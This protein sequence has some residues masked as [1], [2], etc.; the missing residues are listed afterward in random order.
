VK[1]DK[2][3][4]LSSSKGYQLVVTIDIPYQIMDAHEVAAFKSF[5]LKL[6]SLGCRLSFSRKFNAGPKEALKAYP[7]HTKFIE[8]IHELDP[9]NMFSNQMR[10]DFFGV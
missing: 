6:I 10:R 4:Y 5:E 1:A 2:E 8:A 3:G 7:E 9:Y